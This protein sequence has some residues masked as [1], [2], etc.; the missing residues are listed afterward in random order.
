MLFLNNG[1]SFNAP[2]WSVSIEIVCYIV[3]ALLIC[4]Q[5]YRLKLGALS[6][7][8]FLYISKF[9]FPNLS[10]FQ[11]NQIGY[12]GIYFF[13][14]VCLLI[15]VER[16][17]LYIL[18]TAAPLVTLFGFLTRTNSYFLVI[19]GIVLICLVI[20]SVSSTQE[21]LIKIFRDL[22]NLTYASYLIHVPLQIVLLI[23]IQLAELNQSLIVTSEIFFVF[24]F[25]LVH[26][27]SFLT[28]RFFEMPTRL[29]IRNQFNN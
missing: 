28:Y 16:L 13:S 23:I 6:I 4:M 8:T 26:V 12:C 5:E 22:G 21:K 17:P 3:F 25:L 2:I 20:E 24:W 18:M 14:G 11:V 9:T 1:S 29:W 19:I 15:L 27:I 10:F 7:L